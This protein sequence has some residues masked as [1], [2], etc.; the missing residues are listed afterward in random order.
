[1][2]KQVPKPAQVTA[3]KPRTSQYDL[4]LLGILLAYALITVITPRFEAYDAS[5]PK[6]LALALLNLGSY[7]YLLTRK[8]ILGSTS[9]EPGFF[10]N[11]IGLAYTLLLGL[12]LLS[13]VKAINLTESLFTFVRYI[14]VFAAA[15]NLFY[16]F[17]KERQSLPLLSIV[18]SLVLLAD[19]LTVFYNIFL[20]ISKQLPSIYEIK[21]VYSNKNMLTAAIFV[22]IPFAL[23]L[24]SFGKGWRRVLGLV[25][26]FFAL[27]AIL[28][29]SAR[30]FYLGIL[31]LSLFYSAYLLI[32]YRRERLA[33]SLHTLGAY[34]GALLLA[35]VL[36]SLVQQYLYPRT[37]DVYNESFGKRLA[38]AYTGD[39]S[40]TYRLDSWKRSAI[41]VGEN[42]WLG[43]GAGNW[44]V[45]VLEY[46]IPANADFVLMGKA[47]NDFIEVT[48]ESGIPGG[49]L[50][51]SLFLMLFLN[52]AIAFLRPGAREADYF[53]LFLPAFGILCYS[54]DAFFNFPA[55]RPE[56]QT[57]FALFLAAGMAFSPPLLKQKLPIPA[58]LS[59][60]TSRLFFAVL[61]VCAYIFVLNYNSLK[62]QLLAAEDLKN[63]TPLLP[64][65]MFTAGFPRIPNL[66]AKSEP[67]AVTKA[68]YLIAEK[69]YPE[70]ISLLK[71]DESSPYLS[72]KE[73]YLMMAYARMGM[74]D[75][76]LVYAWQALALKPRNFKPLSTI[77]STLKK[78]GQQAEAE[79]LLLGFVAKEKNN[80]DAWRQLSLL[81]SEAGQTAKALSTIDSLSKYSPGDTINLESS[82]NGNAVAVSASC[83]EILNTA[84][85]YFVRQNFP[86]ALK[87]L[88]E[89]IALKPNEAVTYVN[90][91][92]CFHHEK[93]YEKCISDIEQALR[94]GV[95][96][97]GLYNLRGLC[98]LS[99]GKTGPA[100]KD[101]QTAIDKGDREAGENLRKFCG[102][103]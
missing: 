4:P 90:R 81:Y 20:Y 16:I 47:H 94:L 40:T 73:G 26:V 85:N 103:K 19:S 61:V 37:A 51:L 72:V 33:R 52:F 53:S 95:E 29:M 70:A 12:V 84:T 76:A 42:P 11:A 69:K 102:K 31:V 6:F 46:E 62:L 34:L 25:A 74:D 49:L 91:A 78:K 17:R 88:N 59:S 58:L 71:Q 35:F 38:T 50:F 30:S 48:A 2:K 10:H 9:T 64:S 18:M 21:S 86:M 45:R 14:T 67:I 75:S 93:E 83:Q 89:Y 82:A 87:Y 65:S 44:K 99:L 54:V 55:S 77:C 92:Y 97:P 57:L 66:G 79:K 13:F 39:V 60:F 68:R 43:V 24:L 1:M 8:D 101:F 23:Y 22:K 41:L 27:H 98:Y 100:C 80:A 56:M 63:E 15:Y 5:G 36:F 28:Y 96:N 7:L 3:P 32:L